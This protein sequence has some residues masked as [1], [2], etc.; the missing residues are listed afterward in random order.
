ME[1]PEQTPRALSQLLLDLK[2]GF[3]APEIR[4]DALLEAFHERGFGFFLFL[5]ALPAA[6]PLPAL[7]I[8]TVIALPLLLLTVQQMIGR[9]TIW[10]PKSLRSKTLKKTTLDKLI[11]SALPYVQKGEALIRPRL[12]FLTQGVF[13]YLIGLMGFIM[14]LSVALPVPLTNTVPSFGIAAMA[15]GVLMRDGVA[16]LAGALI[17]IGWICV[18]TCMVIFFGAEGLDILKETIKSWL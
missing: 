17:G 3:T 2:A 1:N 13:S 5:I 15:V 12:G 8:N 4:V 6:L 9:H 7:G 18:L 14:A 16:V 10:V 11:D